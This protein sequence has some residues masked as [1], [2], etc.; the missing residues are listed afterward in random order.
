[1]TL[2]ELSTTVPAVAKIDGKWVQFSKYYEKSK[3]LN[4]EA[5][6]LEIVKNWKRAV[7]K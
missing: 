6:G 1:M 5:D 4:P 7:V 2:D 3:S